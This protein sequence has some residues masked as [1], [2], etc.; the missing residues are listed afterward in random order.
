MPTSKEATIFVVI[1][2]LVIV[3]VFSSTADVLAKPK[4]YHI[5]AGLVVLE[6]FNA[7]E[8]FQLHAIPAKL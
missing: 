7:A 3:L 8:T 1:S 2:L 6:R 4:K 5:I